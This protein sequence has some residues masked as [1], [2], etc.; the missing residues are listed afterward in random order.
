[1]VPLKISRTRSRLAIGLIVLA[2]VEVMA[3]FMSGGANLAIHAAI[4]VAFILLVAI[5]DRRKIWWMALPVLAASLAI[6][7][8]TD[9]R[10][11]CLNGPAGAVD[12]CFT[13]F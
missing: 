10:G 5:A 7:V 2:H 8:A 11:S 13:S 1:M 9:D 4:L 3:V 6:L 12:V